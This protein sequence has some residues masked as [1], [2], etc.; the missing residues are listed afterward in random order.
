MFAVFRSRR[1]AVLFGLGFSSGLPLTLTGQTLQAWATDAHVDLKAIAALSLVGLAYTLKFL[2]AP[3]FDRYRVPWL[4]RRRGW[5]L[6]LQIL[7]AGAIAAL[8]TCDPRDPARLAAT[9]V[10]VALLSA[11][12]DTVLDAYNA[13]VLAPEQRAAG[14]AV[15]VLGYRVAYLGGTMLALV[16]S[17]RVA[18]SAIYGGFA[19]LMAVGI[20]TTLAAEEPPGSARPPRSLASAV[21]EPF[22]ELAR[23][24]GARRTALVLAFAALYE[25]V[26]FFA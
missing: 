5:A 15:Y 26:Y 11:S 8:A 4:G 22:T 10:V 24:L 3:V 9:A 1:M 18:W 20:V 25:F 7:L 16:L 12:Q 19:A 23:R 21:V 13:D 2:W 6:L 14:S 17:D